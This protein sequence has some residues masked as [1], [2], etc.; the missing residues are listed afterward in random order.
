MQTCKA[1]DGDVYSTLASTKLTVV[2]DSPA[3]KGRKLQQVRL[4][5]QPNELMSTYT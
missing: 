3:H 2:K 5:R 1:K 4:N